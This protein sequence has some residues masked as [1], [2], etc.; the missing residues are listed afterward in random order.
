M[1][2]VTAIGSAHHRGVYRFN[3]LTG[4]AAV[5]LIGHKQQ[6]SGDRIYLVASVLYTAVTLRLGDF[7]VP[8]VRDSQQ[9]RR[10]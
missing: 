4:V 2:E 3:L 8:S 1:D 9:L 5:V 7:C 6:S 10:S